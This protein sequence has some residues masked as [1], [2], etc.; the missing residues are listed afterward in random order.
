MISLSIQVLFIVAGF[1][2]LIQLF[3]VGI[4]WGFLL[5]VCRS[6][7]FCTVCSSCWGLCWFLHNVFLRLINILLSL[8]LKSSVVGRSQ[9]YHITL[10][11][12][13]IKCLVKAIRW[14]HDSIPQISC[15]FQ[16]LR[17]TSSSLS[18]HVQSTKP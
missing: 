10:Y 1:L 17:C 11:N 5:V 16:S 15:F 7:R 3:I 18:A 2:L 14:I 12:P 9:A 4:S 6:G 8:Y 13:I